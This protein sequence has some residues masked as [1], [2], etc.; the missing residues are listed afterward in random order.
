MKVLSLPSK[1]S[2]S[3][4]RGTY[5]TTNA[6]YPFLTRASAL[7]AILHDGLG[8]EHPR[9]QQAMYITGSNNNT[10]LHNCRVMLILKFYIIFP[11]YD[12]KSIH[13]AFVLRQFLHLQLQQGFS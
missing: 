10:I 5:N 1:T 12:P 11:W 2:Y 7:H 8:H 6:L 9:T 3:I 4:F 13:E